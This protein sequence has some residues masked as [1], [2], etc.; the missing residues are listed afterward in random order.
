MQKVVGS[1]PISRLPRLIRPVGRKPCGAFCFRDSLRSIGW[2]PRSH[3]PLVSGMGADLAARVARRPG[4]LLSGSCD[5]TKKPELHWS[6]NPEK[7]SLQ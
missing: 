6:G 4:F 1:N 2:V 5:S 3:K 7:T